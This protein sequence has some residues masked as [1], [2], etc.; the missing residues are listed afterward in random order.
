MIFILGHT[1][2]FAQDRARAAGLRAVDWRYL[3]DPRQLVGTEEPRIVRLDGPHPR[4][5]L[6]AIQREADSRSARWYTEFDLMQ[7]RI[8]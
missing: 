4:R 2:Q 1:H 8:R 6:E 7:G 5:N 3:S